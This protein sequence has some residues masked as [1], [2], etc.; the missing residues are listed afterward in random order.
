M[1]SPNPSQTLKSPPSTGKKKKNTK[2][3]SNLLIDPPMRSAASLVFS[4]GRIC[5]A[6]MEVL[7]YNG[8]RWS[9]QGYH[10]KGYWPGQN[11]TAAQVPS[12]VISSISPFHVKCQAPSWIWFCPAHISLT[13]ASFSTRW[14]FTSH[15]AKQNSQI[16]LPVKLYAMPSQYLPTSVVKKSQLNKSVQG[17]KRKKSSET[18]Q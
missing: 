12:I 1:L 3:A 4:F 14:H 5:C 11:L 17:K 18:G 8:C 6:L 9:F 15:W 16:S 2:K 13:S 7:R 10:A